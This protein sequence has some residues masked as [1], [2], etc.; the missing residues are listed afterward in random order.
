M[1]PVGNEVVVVGSLLKMVAEGLGAMNTAELETVE[2]RIWLGVKPYRG[3]SEG[4][5]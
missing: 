5:A 4:I 3:V 1:R 2:F